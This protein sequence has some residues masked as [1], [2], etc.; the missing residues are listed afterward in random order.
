M[1]TAYT[2]HGV[3]RAVDVK[4][5]RSHRTYAWQTACGWM[6]G[7]LRQTVDNV[8]LASQG[9]SCTL[10][11]CLDLNESKKRFICV[12]WP[13][14]RKFF[15]ISSLTAGSAGVIVVT[16]RYHSPQFISLGPSY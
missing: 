11:W 14:N 7:I 12:Y 9:G 10:C 5:G 13:K 16:A 6:A 3:G 8:K 15:S 4:W 1:V 2:L